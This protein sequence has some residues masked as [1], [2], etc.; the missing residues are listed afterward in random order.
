MARRH[1]FGLGLCLTAFVT[2]GCGGVRSLNDLLADPAKYRDRS[3]TV[4]GTVAESAS[5][6]GNG[7][8]RITDDEQGLWIVTKSGAPR[9]GARVEVTGR[10]RDGYDISAFGAGRRLPPS[11]QNGLVLVESSHKARN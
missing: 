5:V 11:L 8:Y 10:L 9:K 7:A 3:V 6:M 4:R 1:L 2:A